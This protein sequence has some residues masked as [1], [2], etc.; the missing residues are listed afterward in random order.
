MEELSFENL[1]NLTSSSNIIRGQKYFKS[2]TVSNV[3]ILS[4]QLA[5]GRVNGTKTYHILIKKMSRRYEALCT[6]PDDSKLFCKHSVAVFLAIID[7]YRNPDV[8]NDIVQ[9]NQISE[10]GRFLSIFK[11]RLASIYGKMMAFR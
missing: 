8:C 11:F 10:W 6:C 2:G 3:L 4:D 5:A 9:R 7:Y 1:D